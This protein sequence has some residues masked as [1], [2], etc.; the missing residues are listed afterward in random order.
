MALG[1]TIKTRREQLGLTQEQLAEKATM[2]QGALSALEVRDSARTDFLLGLSRALRCRPEDLLSGRCLEPD[3]AFETVSTP[4]ALPPQI[5]GSNV[6]GGPL[7]IG[8]MQDVP[9]V[10]TAQLGDNG[11]WSAL[12]YPVG[13]GDGMVR[14]PTLD[15]NAYALRVKGDSMRPRIKPGEFVLIEPNASVSPGDEVLVQTKDGRSMVKVLDFRRGGMVQLSSVNEDHKP[16]TF[17]ESEIEKI[18]RCSGIIPASLYYRE[19]P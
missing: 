2:S 8:R 15:A 11:F 9:V 12:D 6:Q 13:F 10:G 1:K 19:M 16:I 3:Y 7:H 4:S 14:Y 5:E 18:H 17:D